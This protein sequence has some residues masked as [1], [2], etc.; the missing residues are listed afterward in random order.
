METEISMQ[1]EWQLYFLFKM[2][3]RPFTADLCN[4]LTKLMLLLLVFYDMEYKNRNI[5]L[6][7]D[8]LYQHH[9]CRLFF[10]VFF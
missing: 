7:Y 4:K 3:K 1:D 5:F 10:F 6:Y 9:I 8:V 2:P